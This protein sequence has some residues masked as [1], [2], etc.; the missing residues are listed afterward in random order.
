MKHS[1]LSLLLLGLFFVS[2]VL[3]QSTLDD[4]IADNLGFCGNSYLAYPVHDQGITALTPAPRGYRPFYISHYGRHGSRWLLSSRNYDLPVEELRKGARNGKLTSQGDAL[5]Q[6]LETLRIAS[7]GR[8]GELT[9]LG[10]QQHQ[11]IARRMAANFPEVFRTTRREGPAHVDCK[12]STAMR[13]ALSMANEAMILKEIYP[14]LDISLDASSADMQS[15]AYG[16]DEEVRQRTKEAR[17]NE[18]PAY[19]ARHSQ[20]SHLMCELFSDAAFVRD[21]IDTA[22]F[23]EHFSLIA[24]NEQSHGGDNHLLALFDQEEAREVFLR[25]NAQW[26]VMRGKS[27]I[28]GGRIPLLVA[29]SLVATIVAEADSVIRQG[30]HG[31]NLRFGH[32]SNLMP[33]CVLLDID[34]AGRA[35]STMDEVE[36]NG[37]WA[38]R[39]V[40]MA[41]NVQLVFY[42]SRHNSEVLV[43]VLLHEHEATLPLPS[44][45][46]PY[47]RWSDLRAYC[48]Q[49]IQE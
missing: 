31:A 46:F 37:W 49:C 32:D 9:P 5:L 12:S 33:L 27:A 36:P 45:L 11:G 20:T 15:I 14:N 6:E 43:K 42:R 39:Y 25:D 40:P 44:E 35:L 8:T 4:A 3:A 24:S 16:G 38:N 18:I 30:G 26:H 21:S 19:N 34:C 29:R 10:A 7:Q 48:L 1:P 41:G 22:A 2:P 13:C 23:L 17:A 47:Y 28:T